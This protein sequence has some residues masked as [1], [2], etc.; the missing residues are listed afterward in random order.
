VEREERRGVRVVQVIV[1]WKE[2]GGGRVA[3]V[4]ADHILWQSDGSLSPY[5]NTIQIVRVIPEMPMTANPSLLP[6]KG[7]S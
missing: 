3:Q 2:K 6:S 7:W 1:E 5:G 4:S